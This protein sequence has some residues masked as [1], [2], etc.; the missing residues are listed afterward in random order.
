MDIQFI[1]NVNH[2][3]DSSWTQASE[4]NFLLRDMHLAMH[5]S[6]NLAFRPEEQKR[7]VQGYLQGLKYRTAA[8]SNF[9]RK[10]LKLVAQF[11]LKHPP[12]IEF[13]NSDWVVRY[14]TN[15]PR[16]FERNIQQLSF[17]K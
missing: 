15:K 17:Q 14:S 13:E 16:W 3:P 6:Q 10:R 7:L 11:V 2:H 12:T 9:D 4:E 8:W 1:P 5:H